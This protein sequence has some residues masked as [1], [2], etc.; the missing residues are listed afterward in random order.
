MKLLLYINKQEI[1]TGRKQVLP[2]D[3]HKYLMS[4][5]VGFKLTGSGPGP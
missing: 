3:E 5:R 2:Q 4:P 1:G